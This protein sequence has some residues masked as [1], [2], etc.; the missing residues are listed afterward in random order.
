MSLWLSYV[1][2][3]IESVRRT[4]TNPCWESRKWQHRNVHNKQVRFNGP[5]ILHVKRARGARNDKVLGVSVRCNHKS[6]KTIS[7]VPFHCVTMNMYVQPMKWK[8]AKPLQ[9]PQRSRWRFSGV[10]DFTFMRICELWRWRTTNCY[11][12]CI[13]PVWPP[14]NFTSV[15]VRIA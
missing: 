10:D 13:W 2:A 15:T 9:M 11:H 5:I 3:D 14:P 8:P 4:Y 12:D 7:F 1:C 6:D